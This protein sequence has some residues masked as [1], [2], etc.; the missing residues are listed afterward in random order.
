MRGKPFFEWEKHLPENVQVPIGRL[1]DILIANECVLI[2]YRRMVKCSS[3]TSWSGK[4]FLVKSATDQIFYILLS[5]ADIPTAWFFN[6]FTFFQFFL[7]MQITF[8]EN[9]FILTDSD[10]KFLVMCYQHWLT[11]PTHVECKKW[12]FVPLCITHQK[13]FSNN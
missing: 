5:F 6:H 2:I 9:C 13:T 3:I 12:G 8:A 11:Y 1:Y 10:L 7:L 4:T